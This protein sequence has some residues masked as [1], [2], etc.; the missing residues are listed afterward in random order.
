M[1]LGVE[2][3]SLIAMVIGGLVWGVRLEGRVNAND[4]ANENTQKDVDDLRARHETLQSELVKDVNEIKIALARIQGLLE[5]NQ[6]ED[7][8]G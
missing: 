3:I 4:K 5:R 2:V 8:N 7:S 1:N 6:R